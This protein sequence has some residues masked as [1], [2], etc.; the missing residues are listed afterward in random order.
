MPT[1]VTT[2]LDVGCATGDFGASVKKLKSAKVW[3]VEVRVKE[4]QE[5]QSKLDQVFI[6]PIEEHLNQLPDKYFDVIFF[7][8]VLEH[9]IDPESTLLSLVPKLSPEGVFIVAIPNVRYFRNLRNLIIKKDWEYEDHGI[10]DRT[11]LRFYTEKSMKTMFKRL[12]FDVLA[13]EG[14]NPTSSVR[15]YIYHFL[16]L[17]IFGL[18]TR[19]LQFASVLR[20][21]GK[22]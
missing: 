19:Y 4:G 1:S 14:I 3:G 17:G 20:P 13:F 10:L 11:H 5:A 9:L 12:N 8:D 2:A 7:N 16:T 21:K 22:K 15:P 6:G 18:D